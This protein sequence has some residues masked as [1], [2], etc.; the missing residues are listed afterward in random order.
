MKLSEKI[1]N[2]CLAAFAVLLVAAGAVRTL[3][4]EK[5]INTYENRYAEKINEFSAE[6][7]MDGSFQES[8]ETA[9]QDQIPFSQYG[10]K[11]YNDAGGKLVNLFASGLYRKNPMRYSSIGNMKVFGGDYLVYDTRRLEDMTPALDKKIENI[12]GVIASHPEL[13]IYMYYIEKDT[14]INFETNEKVFAYEYIKAALDLP[15]DH[16]AKF[17]IDSF[18]DYSREFYR[19]DHHWNCEGSYEGYVQVAELLGLEDVIIPVE[20]VDT[21]YALSGSKAIESG[22]QAV[23]T[24][25]FYAYR[26]ELP[27]MSITINGVAGDDYGNQEAYLSGSARD[28]ISYGNFYGGD[29]GEIIFDTG[30]QGKGNILI[31]GESHDNAILKLLAAGFDKTYSVDLRNYQA[32]LG[33]QFRLSEYVETN[34]IDKLLLIGSIGFYTS[35]ETMLEE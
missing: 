12:N 14:D 30:S 7:Y 20:K 10:K 27:D 4:F 16:M 23:F 15:K 25:P 2:I 29:D 26:F 3:F 9:L 19:T 32:Q 8:V 34:D 17:A 28:E 24:E 22:N 33:K 21:G 35:E 5:D 13:D 1:S 18:E 31:I 6:G 11:L